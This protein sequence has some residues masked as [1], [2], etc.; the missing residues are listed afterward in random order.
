M[1]EKVVFEELSV[2][3]LAGCELSAAAAGLKTPPLA[4]RPKVRVSTGDVETR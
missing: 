4:V 2:W 1:W 3:T